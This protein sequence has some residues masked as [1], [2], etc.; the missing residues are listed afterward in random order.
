MDGGFMVSLLIKNGLIITVDKNRRIIKDGAIAIDNNKIVDVGKTDAIE[1]KYSAE[2]IIDAKGN[3]VMPGLINTH[4]H[5]WQELG[6]GLGT[7]VELYTWLNTAWRL[8]QEN[9][10][11]QDYYNAIRIGALE[12]IKT[13]T[14]T[15]LAYEHA[16]NAH[17]EALDDVVRALKESKVRSLLAIGW[18]DYGL[19]MG[20]PPV[21][22]RE[23][24]EVLK[25]LNNAFKKY[26]NPSDDMFKIWVAPSTT[27]FCTKESLVEAKKIA[28]ENKV[29][30]TIHTNETKTSV[31]HSIKL[32]GVPEIEYLY[33]IG[34][35]DRNVV[36]VHSVWASDKEIELLAK[37][38]AS[39]SH[40]P[41]SNMYLASGIAPISKM[42]KSGVIVGLATDGPTSNNNMDMFDVI[43]VT[44]L[45]QK[46]G[47][48][49]PKSLTAEQTIE[50]A[51][52]GGAKSVLLES[53][54]GSIEVGKLAD[55]IIVDIHNPRA[56]PMANPVANLVY[57]AS[58][59][60]VI[61]TI[62]NGEVL[63]ENRK[64]LIMNEEEVLNNAQ[65]S[66]ERI[67]ARAG[68]ES[69]GQWKIE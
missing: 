56:L 11:S 50:M 42:L 4:V 52:I 6:K 63:M 61:T 23:T 53:K 58:S 26:H 37:T 60:N 38:G 14:T 65:K 7:D 40:N 22:Y 34:I 5:I 13:G 48:L 20:L 59:G 44:P 55:I 68:V 69:V 16:L 62:V 2:K 25:F 24:D 49:D 12:A 31:E 8:L 47:T 3:I 32:H 28:D 30:V 46:V 51:T 9:M 57:S 41:V 67:L 19:E 66:L 43:R 17:P 54:L 27:T 36:T 15:V 64:V 21:A 35:L 33:N 1:K 29:G 45:L 39:V 18:Q 10:N